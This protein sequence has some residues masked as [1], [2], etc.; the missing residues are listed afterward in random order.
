M[1]TIVPRK[2]KKNKYI[3][4]GSA[5]FLVLTVLVYFRMTKKRT[6]EVQK[7]ELSIKEVSVG[8]FE[9]FMV[10]QAKVEPLNYSR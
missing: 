3:L 10:F 6:L 2:S 7:T 8:F 4:V 5:L 9:D 1:D